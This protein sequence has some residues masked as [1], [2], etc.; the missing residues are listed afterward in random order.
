MTSTGPYTESTVIYEPSSSVFL[1]ILNTPLGFLDFLRQKS[2]SY[3]SLVCKAKMEKFYNTPVRDYTFL[4]SEI[5][6]QT[7]KNITSDLARQILQTSTLNGII[8]TKMLENGMLLNTNND[9]EKLN[10]SVYQ[11]STTYKQN[12]YQTC[13]FSTRH[14]EFP[15]C[16]NYHIE[17]RLK[18][19]NLNN[20]TTCAQLNN[21]AI[22]INGIS[23]IKGDIL[24]NGGIIHILEKPIWPAF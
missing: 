2:P 15:T 12:P 23:L 24:V 19:C 18:N 6:E 10:V 3:Y 14:T 8:T 17:C 4:I 7:L 21:R 9:Y 11:P 16:N 5:P 13:E 1:G 22:Q 20:I